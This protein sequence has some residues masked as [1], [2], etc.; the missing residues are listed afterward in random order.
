[1][2]GRWGAAAGRSAAAGHSAVAVAAAAAADVAENSQ[3]RPDAG[4][5][6]RFA[7]PPR[8][9]GAPPRCRDPPA[10]RTLTS[11]GLRAMINPCR[12]SSGAAQGPRCP[13]PRPWVPKRPRRQSTPRDPTWSPAGF[14]S[15]RRIAPFH[16]VGGRSLLT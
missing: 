10:L 13:P 9:T 12:V 8:P 2:G 1:M 15:R 4:T 6:G 5:A 11:T 3:P 16:T 7:R 14:C